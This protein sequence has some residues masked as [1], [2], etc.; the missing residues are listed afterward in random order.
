MTPGFH[1]EETKQKN[2][3]TKNGLPIGVKGRV[4]LCCSNLLIW[5]LLLS[6]L[7]VTAEKLCGKKNSTGQGFKDQQKW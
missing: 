4:R 2:V 7:T 3:L 1:R 6:Q 5:N